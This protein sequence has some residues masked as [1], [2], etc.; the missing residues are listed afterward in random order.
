MVWCVISKIEFNHFYHNLYTLSAFMW[1]GFFLEYKLKI[2]EHGKSK[3]ESDVR[4]QRDLID[5]KHP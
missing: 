5:V 4:S 2:K 1:A 3:S